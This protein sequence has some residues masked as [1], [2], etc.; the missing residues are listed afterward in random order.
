MLSTA[1]DENVLGLDVRSAPSEPRRNPLPELRFPFGPAVLERL[2]S[3]ER[4]VEGFREL[5][6][7]KEPRIG[8]SPCE[9][10]DL[11][12]LCSGSLEIL[13]TGPAGSSHEAR[14]EQRACHSLA[15]PFALQFKSIQ[16]HL[17]HLLEALGALRVV[18]ALQQ[19][20]R[21][22]GE[23]LGGPPCEKKYGV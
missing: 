4:R 23:S 9:G 8:Q 10:D 14:Q 3:V 18:E 7:G 13:E 5:V 16:E 6:F 11:G 12:A 1:R 19:D 22:N 15:P 21:P 20:G 17:G 2:R